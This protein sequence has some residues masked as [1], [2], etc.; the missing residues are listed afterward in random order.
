MV[1]SAKSDDANTISQFTR[2]KDIKITTTGTSTPASYQVK[3]TIAY[4]PEMQSLFQDIRFNTKAGVYIDYWIESKTA[5]T[6]ATVWLELPDAITDGNSDT[7]WMYY[8]NAGLSDGGVGA[9]T[10]IAFDDFST[11]TSADY[12]EKYYATWYPMT[13]KT[14]SA[15]EF[16]LGFNAAEYGSAV[17]YGNQVIT[18]GSYILRS[19]FRA[20]GYEDNIPYDRYQSEIGLTTGAVTPTNYGSCSV[21]ADYTGWASSIQIPMPDYRGQSTELSGNTI[22]EV[23][24]TLDGSNY[25]IG[26]F[27]QDIS[28]TVPSSELWIDFALVRKYIANEPT[29]SVGTAQH[30]RRVP[31]FM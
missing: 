16:H 4:E 27:V 2:R 12:T 18:A 17:V 21:A 29:A 8:G 14:V 10:F 9:D 15:G 11:D 22:S 13:Y 25:Y 5:S 7:I 26:F 3:V 28:S 23:T 30:Q 24:Y 1:Y 31:Q 20:V 19:K 6:T